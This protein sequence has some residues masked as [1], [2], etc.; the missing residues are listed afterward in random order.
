MEHG[1]A[2]SDQGEVWEEVE[3]V[4]AEARAASPTMAMADAVEQRRESL[5]SYTEA[6][7]YPEGARGVLVAIDGKFA[8]LDIFE[9][10]DILQRIWQRLVTGYALD[11]IR[12]PD[13]E[14]EP[15]EPEAVGKIMEQVA[16]VACEPCPSV[17]IGEDWRFESEAVIGQALVAEDAC[18]HL[19][20][21]PNAGDDRGR[22]RGPRIESP[23]RRGRRQRG[24]ER[25]D[26]DSTPE[27]FE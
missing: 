25:G 2:A 19:S 20:A 3:D 26:Q 27:L 13:G 4:V 5:D 1:V 14:H 17:G 11:A 15:I 12:T 9:K 6:L 7:Q 24:R 8:A 22:V 16:E 23:S 10:P 21:F 18:V